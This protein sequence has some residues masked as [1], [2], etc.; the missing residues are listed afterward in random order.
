MSPGRQASLRQGPCV[1]M[2]GGEEGATEPQP[3]QQLGWLPL[4][5]RRDSP[6]S[7]HPP[8]PVGVPGL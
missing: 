5:S 3:G 2:R 6:D 1:L 8:L 7:A 4:P